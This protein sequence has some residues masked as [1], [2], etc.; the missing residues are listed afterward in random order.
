[1]DVTDNNN[2][3]WDGIPLQECQMTNGLEKSTDLV[4]DCKFIGFL[5]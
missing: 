2:P 4:P 1:V 5:P 3:E